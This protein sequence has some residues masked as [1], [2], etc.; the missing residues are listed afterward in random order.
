MSIA[1]SRE[2]STLQPFWSERSNKQ[3]YRLKVQGI[4][5]RIVFSR[6]ELE[7]LADTIHDALGGAHIDR[8][9]Q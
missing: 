4:T 3:L 8:N 7:A 9:P 2:V 1:Q 5:K 6:E